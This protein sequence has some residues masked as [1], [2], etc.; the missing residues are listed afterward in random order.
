MALLKEIAG[1]LNE[2]KLQEYRYNVVVRTKVGGFK[3]YLET[4]VNAV[5]KNDAIQTVRG[6]LEASQEDFKG[7]MKQKWAVQAITPIKP[8]RKM[9]HQRRMINKG[10]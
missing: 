9:L 5:S 3:L 10:K 1:G 7:V 4:N 2:T 6:L 8:T